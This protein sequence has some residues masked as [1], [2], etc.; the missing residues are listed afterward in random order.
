MQRCVVYV[1]VVRRSSVGCVTM[2]ER[3]SLPSQ[4]GLLKSSAGRLPLPLPVGQPGRVYFALFA[5]SVSRPHAHTDAS[6]SPRHAAAAHLSKHC[7]TNG[8]VPALPCFARSLGLANRTPVCMMLALARGALLHCHIFCKQ[9][10]FGVF[11]N[12]NDTVLG[13]H[14]QIPRTL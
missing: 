8:C 2:S 6:T 9:Q 10:R 12:S 7:F 4:R 13:I 1:C 3:Q 11:F 5:N 14:A